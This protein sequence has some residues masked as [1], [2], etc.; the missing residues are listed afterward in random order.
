MLRES[1][2]AANE[3]DMIIFGEPY[4]EEAYEGGVREFAFMNAEKLKSLIEDNHI[5]KT[6]RRNCSPTAQEYYEFLDRHPLISCYG[7][8]TQPGDDDYGVII[9][10]C[11]YSGAITTEMLIDFVST[12]SKDAEDFEVNLRELYCKY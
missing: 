11:Y 9:L 12:F 4:N 7:Y 2:N 1:E 3:R 5:E 10:G 6:W 8:V